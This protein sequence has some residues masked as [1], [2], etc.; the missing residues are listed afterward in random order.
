MRGREAPYAA[1]R[2]S[3][4]QKASPRQSFSFGLGGADRGLC[5][6]AGAHC[7][8]EERRSRMRLAR[9]VSALLP[10]RSNARSRRRTTGTR[11]VS[12]RESVA[13][14]SNAQAFTNFCG[15]PASRRSIS[16]TRRRSAAVQLKSGSARTICNRIS[17]LSL[18]ARG[19]RNISLCGSTDWAFLCAS[20]S[21][22]STARIETSQSRSWASAASSDTRAG[23]A[24][25][26]LRAR[27]DRAIE[28]RSPPD[29][30]D[31]NVCACLSVVTAATS[32]LPADSPFHGRL[33]ARF[34]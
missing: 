3:F 11:A 27:F 21:R 30:K 7:L 29:S 17:H 13:R 8:T 25:A 24:Q 26:S 34:W 2:D 6:Y 14:L 18:S 9:V 4:C 32:A 31:F 19:P 1:A 12:F 28:R 20:F 16:T 33:E 10:D 23:F 22:R 15:C 5:F